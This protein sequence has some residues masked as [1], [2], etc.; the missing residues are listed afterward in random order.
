MEKCPLRR[1]YTTWL[2]MLTITGTKKWKK[3]SKFHSQLANCWWISGCGTFSARV[4]T[5][6]HKF[7][8]FSSNP[9]NPPNSAQFRSKICTIQLD[10]IN[11]PNSAQFRPKN[12][13]IQLNSTNPPNSAQV[14]SQI[15][16]I[17][18]DFGIVCTIPLNS[19]QIHPQNQ[20]T[21]RYV[22]FFYSASNSLFIPMLHYFSREFTI[23]C[24]AHKKTTKFRSNLISIRMDHVW[25]ANEMH[26]V[27]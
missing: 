26:V 6:P 11:P 4:S 21:I 10:F 17:L 9:Q 13:T 23:F 20:F 1:L 19:A 22:F 3:S 16:F 2:C 25:Y 5:I 15:Y 14:R 8:Q 7:K 24:S 18:L 12:C 27:I